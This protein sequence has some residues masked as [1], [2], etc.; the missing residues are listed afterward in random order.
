MVI[1]LLCP[2]CGSRLRVSDAAAG[3]EVTCRKCD[4]PLH[5]P[6]P[7]LDLRDDYEP[8]HPPTLD[9]VSRGL[10]TPE[11][12]GKASLILGLLS[13]PLICIPL[14]GYLSLACSSVGL[15]LGCV[16]MYRAWDRGGVLSAPADG[17]GAVD[18]LGVHARHFPV[19]GAALCL[20]ALVLSVLPLLR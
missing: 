18:F 10:R 3:R 9:E 20:F 19:F 8:P 11:G 15:V 13:F 14:V 16:G 5:V 4:H 2:K 6:D 7:S 1:R 17:S 12:L